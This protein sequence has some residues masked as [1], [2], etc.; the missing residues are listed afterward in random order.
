LLLLFCARCI[1]LKSS[2][3]A[4]E[5][6]LVVD[7]Y[8]NW[9]YNVLCDSLLEGCSL[10][11]DDFQLSITITHEH[12]P[13]MIQVRGDNP[14]MIQVRGDNPAMIQVRGDNPAMLQVRGDNPAMLQVTGGGRG[15]IIWKQ[16]LT[17]HVRYFCPSVTSVHHTFVFAITREQLCKF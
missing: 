8:L 17:Y 11:I 12:N 6:R 2:L 13:A 1:K 7:D 3:T 15:Y 16:N 14:A 10:T 5:V 9:L 4:G